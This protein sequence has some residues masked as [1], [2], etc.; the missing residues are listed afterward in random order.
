MTVNTC[1]IPSRTTL[2]LVRRARGDRRQCPLH[3]G[4]EATG[5]CSEHAHLG[6]LVGRAA[7]DLG[8]AQCCQ[9]LL[10][11]LQLYGTRGVGEQEGKRR[12]NNPSS[13]QNGHCTALW[14][15]QAT[16]LGQQVRLGLRPQLMD[17]EL[18]CGRRERRHTRLRSAGFGARRLCR[19]PAVGHSCPLCRCRRR[20]NM[21]TPSRSRRQGSRR[22]EL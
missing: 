21:A 19:P 20:P 18:G 1:A 12:G 7:G 6:Q 11:V 4:G 3:K 15:Q 8:H 17:L 13:G 22:Q 2:L 16:D 9:L 10:Q 5:G 14:A